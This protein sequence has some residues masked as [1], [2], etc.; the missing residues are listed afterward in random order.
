LGAETDIKTVATAAILR[1]TADISLGFGDERTGMEEFICFNSC[2][3]NSNSGS[4][5]L[6]PFFQ[7]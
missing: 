5:K 4:Y 6:L 3:K 1:C 7:D 2:C